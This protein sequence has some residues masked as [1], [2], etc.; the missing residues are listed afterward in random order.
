MP[1]AFS[2]LAFLL[3][4]G[5]FLLVASKA[6][7]VSIILAILFSVPLGLLWVAPHALSV[8]AFQPAAASE[9]GVVALFFGVTFGI[10]GALLTLLTAWPLAVY[11]FARGRERARRAA[12]IWVAFILPLAYVAMSVF[13]EF[14]FFVR[15]SVIAA[16]LRHVL[17]GACV[18]S[19]TAV[20]AVSLFRRG[21][22]SVRRFAL[23][24]AA[25]TALA[26]A[27]LYVRARPAPAVSYGALPPLNTAGS[28]PPLLVIGL[29]GGNWR[30]IEPLLAQHRLPTIERLIHDGV[31]GTVRA[32]TPPYWSTPAW[33]SI[34]TGHDIDASRVHSDM[35]AVAPGLSRFQLPLEVDLQLNPIMAFELGLSHS[36]V[37]EAG[38]APRSALPL[39]PI[40]ER[41]TSD[42]VRNAV[43]H[44]PFTF[45]AVDQSAYVVSDRTV[46]DLW[47]MMGVRSGPRDRV[48]SPASNAASLLSWF[49]PSAPIDNHEIDSILLRPDG[50]KP[51]D[52]IVDPTTT[53]RA[54]L[55]TSQRMFGVT[56]QIISSDRALRAMFFY[57][58]DF[59]KVCHAFW[60]YRFPNDFADRPKP[61][62]VEALGPVLDRYLEYLDRQFASLIAAFPTSPNVVLLSDHGEES[63]TQVTI[64]KG[65]HS[66][67]GIFVAA[68]PDV[69]PDTGRPEVEYADFAPTVLHLLNVPVP[70]DLSG[71]SVVSNSVR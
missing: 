52:A 58:P 10:L 3:I 15:L 30:T 37:I 45:P 25:V 36:G 67:H 16:E 47:E 26:L 8:H 41:L 7:R 23:S 19:F 22:E 39:A 24:S 50:P 9:W 69:A 51:S 66:E 54:V 43:V 44:F 53:V 61:E 60:Q 65:W 27:V 21:G 49:G 63:T 32:Q 17:V 20:L 29:D 33:A 55:D 64:W 56:R 71:H 35:T 48:V 31:R 5:A 14:G 42:G 40:W 34:L 18:A 4:S 28:S 62:D 68:G 59:D 1:T 38:P 70:A 12:A 2:A 6:A 57:T 13:V 46:T 11:E